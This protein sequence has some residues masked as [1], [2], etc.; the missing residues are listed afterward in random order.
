MRRR[1][2]DRSS[3]PVR[4]VE[5][6]S[7]T[8]S[9]L[10]ARWP[11]PTLTPARDV[12]R[13]RDDG[14]ERLPMGAGG[15]ELV[16]R[17]GS[18]GMAEVF[19]AH[20]R[21]LHGIEHT[22]VVKR[23]RDDVRSLPTISKMFTWEA[24]ISSRMCH[25]NIVTFHDFVSYR[26][27]DHLVLEHV[28]GPDIATMSKALVAAGRAFPI[29]AVLEVGIAGARA[30]AHAHALVDDD[31]RCV[32]LVH[33]D[34]SPQN[35][36]VSIDGQIKLIDFGVAKTTSPHVP[37]DTEPTLVKGKMGYIAPEHLRGQALDA[38]ADLYGLGVVLF[39]MLTG[40]PLLRRSADI[41]MIRAALLI[42][43]PMLTTLRPDCPASLDAVVR[44]ALARDPSDRFENATAMARALCEIEASV[45]EEVGTPTLIELARDVYAMHDDRCMPDSMA[46]L[47]KHQLMTSCIVDA[48]AL[49]NALEPETRPE[50]L[51]RRTILPPI[52]P[53]SP[54]VKAVAEFVAPPTISEKTAACTAPVP[55]PD[56]WQVR[57]VP[58]AVA[59]AIGVLVAMSVAEVTR[60]GAS[61]SNKATSGSAAHVTPPADG[62]VVAAEPESK[63]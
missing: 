9:A 50:G 52:E 20:R 6:R 12:G 7:R 38:R 29:R 32:G 10:S 51:L 62:E 16:T 14:P 26:G 30:L 1:R 37:R 25:P 60:R 23:L 58:V 5:R 24:W 18:G 13:S 36:L 21:G 3:G 8:A 28:R 4:A 27:R 46:R 44:R 43:V 19:L 55:K 41:E 49:P 57:V 42:E 40:R 33:R 22:V 35:L 11:N 17:L 59:F 2:R 39:E 54:P 53:A 56:P 48:P 34:V 31:G 63:H 61:A 15:Y 45:P 47:P